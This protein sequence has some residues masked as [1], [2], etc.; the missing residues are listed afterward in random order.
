MIG[1]R[2]AHR[3]YEAL[4]DTYDAWAGMGDYERWLQTLDAIA[5]EHGVPG[6]RLLDVACGTGLSSEPMVE[7]GYDVS[8]CDISPA[9]VRLASRRLMRAG[10]RGRVDVAD[11]RDLPDWGSFDL[12][13]CLCDAVNYLL[14]VDELDAAF[15]S[16]ARRLRPGGLYIFDVNSV[17]TY[18]TLFSTSATYE[19]DEVLFHWHGDRRAEWAS[20]GIFSSR[21]ECV[22][23]AATSVSLHIQRYWPTTVIRQR[24]ELAGLRCVSALGQSPSIV[25]SECPDEWRDR[26]V[27]FVARRERGSG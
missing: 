1:P 10:G 14:D 7:R 23:G 4:A 12:I 13:T 25:M 22:S 2:L 6:R 16:V 8:A 17:G 21:L 20:Q 18:R 26:K 24:L 9:M 15:A 11:M 3:A 19:A 27:V 5:R